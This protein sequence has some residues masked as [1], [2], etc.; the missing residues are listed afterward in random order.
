MFKSSLASEQTHQV[1]QAQCGRSTCLDLSEKVVA[2]LL[3]MDMQHKGATG[4][5]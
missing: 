2:H 1:A 4:D 3:S 5:C